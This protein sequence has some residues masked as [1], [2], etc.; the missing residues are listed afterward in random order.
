MNRATYTALALAFA[1]AILLLSPRGIAQAPGRG[2]RGNYTAPPRNWSQDMQMKITE[3]FTLASVGDMIILRP[4][5]TLSDPGFQ[6]ALKIIRSADVGFGNFE[7]LIRDETRFQGPL[8]GMFGDKSVAADVK[9]MGFQVVNRAGNHLMDSNQ[10]GLFDTLRFMED[11]GLVY[12][13]AGRDLEDARAPH[14]YESPKGRIGVVGMYGE[15]ST[16]GQSRLSASYKVGNTGG[17][18]GLNPIGLMRSIIVTPAELASLK[19]IRDSVFEYRTNYDHPLDPPANEDPGSLDLFGVRYMAGDR[20]GQQSYAMNPAD[21]QGNLRSIRNGKQYADFMIATIHA[22]QGATELQQWLFEDTTPD[23]LVT[24]AHGAIDNGADA[25]V[26]HGPH[27]LAGVEIYKGKPIF[28]NLGE[29]FREWDWGC[30][31]DANPSLPQTSA[32]RNLKQGATAQPVNYESMIA[33]SRYDKG[34]L[35][36][37]RL[38]PIDGGFDSAIS[39]RGVPHMA[40][41]EVARRILERVQKLSQRFG[42][43]IVIDGSTGVI[44]SRD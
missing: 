35:F 10:E 3:P 38:Y 21:F 15:V 39:R 22:H 30:D 4:A 8:G 26:G 41:P 6:G 28:Y 19:K 43:K 5:S 29:F 7:S 17:R 44:T 40:S 20:L 18:P 11:A 23:Y 24:L 34:K 12:A 14:Y 13:G 32:E 27:V 16:G 42:T 36:E 25:F 37:I 1:S 2:G 33:M 31:C 9:A